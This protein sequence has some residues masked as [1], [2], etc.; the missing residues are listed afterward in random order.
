MKRLWYLVA[1]AVAIVFVPGIAQS[2]M[3]DG[4][5]VQVLLLGIGVAFGCLVVV[6][7]L[8]RFYTRR[9]VR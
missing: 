9:T 7:G 2:K 1:V 5:A 3:G 6:L 4:A 8:A